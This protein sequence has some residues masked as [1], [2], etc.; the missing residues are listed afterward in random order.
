MRYS[1]MQGRFKKCQV[2]HRLFEPFA[3]I[4]P[5]IDS[6]FFEED[7]CFPNADWG[8]EPLVVWVG[9]LPRHFR[10]QLFRCRVIPNPDVRV[11]EKPHLGF[12]SGSDSG[13][14]PASQSDSSPIG[15]TISPKIS[16]VPI[17]PPI[18]MVR[19]AIPG[20]LISATAWPKRVTRMGWPVL[21]TRS[22][23]ARQ[24]A[25][26]FEMA[27]SSMALFSQHHDT[28]HFDH[29]PTIV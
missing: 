10:C 24:V 26:N 4:L 22:R 8:Q 3:E 2:C 1:P 19:L 27:I 7:C 21:R 28:R 13:S 11:E 15:P 18:R 29:G 12:F 23:T 5:K 6:S 17:P 20:G 9:Q 14:R 16:M 25:L